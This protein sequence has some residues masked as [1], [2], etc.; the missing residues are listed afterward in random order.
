MLYLSTDPFT[1]FVFKKKGFA[2]TEDLPRLSK[3]DL[4]CGVNIVVNNILHTDL[5]KRK[6]I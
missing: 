1:S 3:S 5:K 2:I 6:T 4:F